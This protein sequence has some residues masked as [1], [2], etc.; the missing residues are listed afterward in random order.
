MT[1]PEGKVV[2]VV[3]ATLIGAVVAAMAVVA[4]MGFTCYLTIL[5]LD[6]A[7]TFARHRQDAVILL[8]VLL[9]VVVGTT[10]L[11]YF[12]FNAGKNIEE[13]GKHK[14]EDLV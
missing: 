7:I 5:Q 2:I 14:S 9:A 10:A 13:D 11:L 4:T 1:D 3:E 6:K 8:S 12:L